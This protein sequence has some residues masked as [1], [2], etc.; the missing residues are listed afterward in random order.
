MR[1]LLLPPLA[2]I[3]LALAGCGNKGALVLPNAA[4]PR[5]RVTAPAPAPS[6]ATPVA[7]RSAG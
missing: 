5:H 3:A 4:P 7:A 1:R 6:S 2:L